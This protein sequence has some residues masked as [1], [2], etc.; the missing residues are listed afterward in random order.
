MILSKKTLPPVDLYDLLGVHRD[1]SQE[2]IARAYRRIAKK[3]HPDRRTYGASKASKMEEIFKLSTM[4]Y[5]ILSEPRKRAEYDRIT[6]PSFITRLMNWSTEASK[7]S[8]SSRARA[9]TA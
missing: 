1:A 5:E 2:E 3:T 7:S 6:R 8:K 4:A 9:K